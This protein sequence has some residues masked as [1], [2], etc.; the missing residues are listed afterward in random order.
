MLAQQCDLKVGEFIWTGGDCHL[1]LNHLD[2]ARTQLAREPG[3]LPRLEIGRRPSMIE[4]YEYED[5]TLHGYDAQPH[6]KAPV[7][8]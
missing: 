2:Q 1:Y 7:A 5:F 8:V 4:E 6:I 3:A